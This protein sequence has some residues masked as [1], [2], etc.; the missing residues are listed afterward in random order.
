MLVTQHLPLL[1]LGKDLEE[2]IKA[3]FGAH[4]DFI[5]NSAQGKQCAVSEEDKPYWYNAIVRAPS[6]AVIKRHISARYA[7]VL[8]PSWLRT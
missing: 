4:V 3:W 8:T 1:D 6:F 2:S 5:Q 7:D